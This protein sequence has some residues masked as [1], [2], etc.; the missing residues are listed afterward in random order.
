MTWKTYALMSGAGVLSMW[1]VAQPS[2]MPGGVRPAQ[3]REAAGAPA[4]ASD[5]EEQANRLQARLQQE[6]LYRE[7][8]RNLFRFA[9]KPA[10]QSTPAPAVEIPSLPVVEQPPAPPPL[11]MR[12][13]G[14]A[15]DQNGDETTRTAILST[16][17]GV[18]L[19]RPGDEVLGRFRVTAIEEEAVEL[20]TIPDGTPVRLTLKK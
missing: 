16:F 7:P 17:S 12:L 8:G 20:V 6:A 9:P 13:A 11:P 1:F 15:T 2:T 19:A 14:V 4:A 10:P 3:P 5:I 18:I